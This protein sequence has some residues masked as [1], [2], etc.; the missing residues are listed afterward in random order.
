MPNLVRR[1]FETFQ[2]HSRGAIIKYTAF[3]LIMTNFK[4]HRWQFKMPG[5]S[6]IPSNFMRLAQKIPL[7]SNA[8]YNSSAKNKAQ[9]YQ[10]LNQQKIKRYLQSLRYLRTDN[11]FNLSL[12]IFVARSTL[13]TRPYM[14]KRLEH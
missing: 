6:Q 11:E 2:S 4:T 14:E 10:N 1:A 5:N 12:R 9:G 3:L 8:V 13:P 7:K